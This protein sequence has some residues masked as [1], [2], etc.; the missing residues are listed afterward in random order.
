MSVEV[1]MF[2]PALQRVVG[3]AEALRLEG[4]TVGECL[5]DLVRCHPD[6]GRLLFDSRGG[7]LKPVYVFV[8]QEGMFKASPDR[9]LKESDRLIIAVLATGG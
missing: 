4:A 6:A 3:D 5:S 7:L 8:N 9:P 1:K 2:Y